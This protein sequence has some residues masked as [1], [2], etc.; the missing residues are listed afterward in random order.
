LGDA[1]EQEF[2]GRTIGRKQIVKRTMSRMTVVGLAIA[3][4]VV[5]T[6]LIAGADQTNGTGKTA[7]GFTVGYNAKADLTGNFE[8]QP[9]INSVDLNIHCNDYTRY[10]QTFT[11]SGFPKSIFNATNCFDTDGVR[12]YVHVEAVDRGEPG[13]ESGDSLCITVKTFP[14]KNSLWTFKDCGT[15]TD[16]NVQIHPDTQDTIVDDG[17]AA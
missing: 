14:A 4:V 5:M 2:D 6:A 8:Y 16:G 12:Y 7:G 3:T 1:E 17:T 10:F 15:I 13:V 11:N 9:T